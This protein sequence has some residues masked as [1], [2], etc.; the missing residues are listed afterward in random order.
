MKHLQQFDTMAHQFEI[1]STTSNYT[2]RIFWAAF[3]YLASQFL[4]TFKF[5][6]IQLCPSESVV[7]YQSTSWKHIQ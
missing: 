2:T 6:C 1:L 3:E 7:P 4:F 5:H